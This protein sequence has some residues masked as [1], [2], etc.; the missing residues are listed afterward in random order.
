[1][2]PKFNSKMF[3]GLV[4]FK[5]FIFSYGNVSYLNLHFYFCLFKNLLNT[6]RQKYSVGYH[7]SRPLPEIQLIR[8]GMSPVEGRT[9][10]LFL[11]FL[12]L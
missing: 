5:F 8:L 9:Y 11:V 12:Y 4:S 2:F 6:L 1:M 7:A 3:L 10:L